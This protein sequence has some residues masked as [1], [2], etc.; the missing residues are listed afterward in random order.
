[1]AKCSAITQAG[2]RCKGTP[3]DSSELCY[4][5]SPETLE[6]RRRN[7]SKGGKRGGRGRPLTELHRLED[8]LESLADKVL[9][10]EVAPGIAAV[11]VQ[12]RNAQI[13]AINAGLKAKEVEE[14]EGR[15]EEV[16][17]LLRQ[18]GSFTTYSGDPR[19]D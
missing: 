4:V 9:E 16:E 18:Q 12:I 7:G 14:L 6:D 17:E 5:H 13:R 1:M 2:T 19:W 3:T 11:V 8:K 10:E 15:L